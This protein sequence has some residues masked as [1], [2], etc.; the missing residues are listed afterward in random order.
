M[1]SKDDPEKNRIYSLKF[2]LS[3]EG[4][5]VNWVSSDIIDS[6]FSHFHFS[7]R[8]NYFTAYNEQG[9][10]LFSLKEGVAEEIGSLNYRNPFI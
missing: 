3:G 10:S 7:N 9:A 6:D 8:G 2:D 1:G 4:F 5:T